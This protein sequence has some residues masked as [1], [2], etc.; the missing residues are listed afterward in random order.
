MVLHLSPPQK[1]H[2]YIFSNQ[3]RKQQGLL[4][5]WQ[6]ILLG[7]DPAKIV[8]YHGFAPIPPQKFHR[9]ISSH[10]GK[11][12]QGTPP[13]IANVASEKTPPPYLL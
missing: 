2:R 4:Q 11:K 7:G 5:G 6:W 10:Q 13:G 8:K 1:F 9:G 3:D 12:Q